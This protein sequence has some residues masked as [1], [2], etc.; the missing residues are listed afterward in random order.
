MMVEVVK[1]EAREGAVQAP[2]SCEGVVWP[3][4]PDLH[5]AVAEQELCVSSMTHHW[6]E[7][8]LTFT[9]KLR[10]PSRPA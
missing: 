9:A 3:R 8:Q 5:H 7:G 1:D 2:Q 10:G 6:I 4:I